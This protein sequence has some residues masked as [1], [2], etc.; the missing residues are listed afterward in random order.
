MPPLSRYHKTICRIHNLFGIRRKYAINDNITSSQIIFFDDES[1]Y[2]HIYV[3]S[4]IE[5]RILVQGEYEVLCTLSTAYG[6][7]L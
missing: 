4:L 7:L 3:D 6:E 1:N 5:G 2:N